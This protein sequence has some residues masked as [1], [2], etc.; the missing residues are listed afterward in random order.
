VTFDNRTVLPMAWRTA[1][2]A[3]A[4]LGG[5]AIAAGLIAWPARTWPNLLLADVYLLTMA[6]AGA[7]FVSMQYLSG[8]GWSVVLRRI[9]EAMMSGLPV[10]A[11]LMLS[12]FFGRHIL[13]PWAQPGGPA[14]GVAMS[15]A[16]AAYLSTPLVFARMFAMLAVW[17]L[18]ARRLRTTSLQ[19]DRDPEPARHRWM[20]RY[21]AAFAVAFAATFTLAS[22]DWLMSLDPR[23]SSTVFAVYVFAG[24]LVSGLAAL[25][26]VAV[27]LRA[28]GPL[29]H[30]VKPSH[31]HDLGKLLLAFST[32]WAYIWV[33]QY[34][35]IWYGNLPDEVTYYVRRT[36]APWMRLFLL[37]VIANWLVPFLVLLPRAAKRSPRVLAAVCAVLLVGHWLDLYLLIMPETWSRPMV[38]PLELI[39]PLGYA[40][41]FVHLM[42]R[43]LARAPLVPLHDPYLDE[44]VNH[45]T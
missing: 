24:L 35:L 17:M 23:W 14:A 43:A 22:V 9:A 11:A 27:V 20:I 5:L 3:L 4:G 31:L 42:S 45:E 30:V 41:L 32:F 28:L 15:P 1:A 6:L 19:Q 10:A 26:L 12:L 40:G 33:S 25:T 8:A 2:L 44:S 18:L 39:I 7:L 38:G 36:D 34:L 16:K 29:R 37:N 13:Y 21:S